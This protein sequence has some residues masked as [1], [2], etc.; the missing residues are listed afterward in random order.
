MAFVDTLL[1]HSDRDII[2]ADRRHA[3]GGHWLDAYPFVRLHQPSAIYGVDSTRLG[4]ERIDTDG[5]NAG[6][7]DRATVAEICAY[8]EAVLRERMLP[9]GRVRFLSGHS[10]EVAQ[11]GSHLAVSRLHGRACRIHVRRAVVDAR[12]L[13]AEIPARRQPPFAVS[14]GARV[15]PPNALPEITHAPSGFTIIGAGKTAMDAVIWLLDHGVTPDKIRWIRPR[16]AWLSDRSCLQALDLAVGTIACVARTTEAAAQARDMGDLFQRLQTA[17]LLAALDPEVEPETFRGA[18]TSKPERDRMRQITAVVRAGHVT[19]IT[20]ERVEMQEGAVPTDPDHV[21]VDCTAGALT[22]RPTRPVFED[23]RITIQCIRF[24]LTCFN[25]ALTAFVESTRSD[26]AEKNRLCP[27]C[28]L[29][30]DARDWITVRLHSLLA[31]AV[32]NAE[33]DIKAFMRASRLNI[34]RGLET[35]GENSELKEAMSTI[36]RCRESA[37]DNLQRLDRQRSAV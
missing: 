9:S 19:A 7:Y 31:E 32:W 25:A 17:G 20:P 1:S 18:Q 14:P 4:V 33:P 23:D 3:P 21:H 24:G 6:Y 35:H 11:D 8:Y 29:P 27:P 28:V 22:P 37:I 16:D 15:I 36:A 5:H 30:G 13:E 10:C 12:Y 2:L 34:L 26:I